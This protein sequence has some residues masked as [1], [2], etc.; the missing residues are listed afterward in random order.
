MVRRLL[1]TAVV[2]LLGAS[3]AHAEIYQWVDEKGG[4]HFSDQPPPAPPR[5]VN[6][7]QR[8]AVAP[9][10][11]AAP[12]LTASPAPP[13]SAPGIA[14]A[15]VSPIPKI[16]A[17]LREERYEALNSF[18]EERRVAAI[19]NP[20]REDDLVAAYHAFKIN[21]PGF[22]PLLDRWVAASP[23]AYQPRLARAKY[24][25]EMGWYARGTKWSSETSDSQFKTMEDFLARAAKDV[26]AT[27]ERE[28][29]I[30]VPYCILLWM[31]DK[32]ESDALA[33]RVLAKALTISPASFHVRATF[34][35]SSTPR[36]G[37]SYEAMAA[38]AVEAK[39]HVREN[40]KLA[41]LAGYVAFDAGD[42][43]RIKKNYAEAE[44]LLTEA[45]SHGGMG[46][47]YVARARVRQEREN[48]GPA[49][50]DAD[51][52]IA[53]WPHDGEYYYQRAL[54]LAELKRRDEALRDLEIADQLTPND[55]D[56]ARARKRLAADYELAG[57]R[58]QQLKDTRGAIGDYSTAIHA[59][60]EG[61]HA[62][63]RRARALI[64]EKRLDEALADLE[65][66]RQV[67][68]DEF[69]VYL[70][71]DWVLAQR[72]EWDRI[73][74]W[75]D[76]FLSRNPDH[77]RAY[78]ERGGAYHHKGDKQSAVRDAKRAADLGSE[79]GRKLYERFA[80][81]AGK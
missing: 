41:A 18:L 9:P 20:L 11:P 67:A 4:V 43:Q 25:Y 28:E 76:Q 44:R 16:R 50:E 58:L 57:Y 54:I 27:L 47:Y 52:A 15:V 5:A 26:K 40:P 10:T 31:V 60:P 56:V 38:V 80:R 35:H 21:D 6:P 22:E 29:R 71:A 69:D 24:L 42:L 68:P 65:R 19:A 51:R 70:L 61:V 34:L 12:A 66:A 48:F 55:K 39:R 64:D 23:K 75:W 63:L 1:F 78:I 59:N 30:I 32:S 37:G 81:N 62:Y 2:L 8:S 49:L 3:A 14:A 33:Q 45:L 36:W 13:P 7:T 53:E 73:I 46:R 17:M 77:S 72:G 79:E 74:G